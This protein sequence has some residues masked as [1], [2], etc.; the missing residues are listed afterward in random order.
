MTP[1]I[2]TTKDENDLLAELIE[3]TATRKLRWGVQ[4]PS[5]VQTNIGP[6]H[7]VLRM[8]RDMLRLTARRD[9][10]KTVNFSIERK[11]ATGD[12]L[13]LLYRLATEGKAE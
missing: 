6:L 7:Y 2:L 10:R 8:R 5:T 13:T 12:G 1:K 4:P 11:A 3:K 9:G